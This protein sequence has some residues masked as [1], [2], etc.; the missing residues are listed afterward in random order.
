MRAYFNRRP[1][2]RNHIGAPQFTGRF[3]A[4]TLFPAQHL[5]K[6]QT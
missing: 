4:T 1:D 3:E 5:L 6:I 2:I